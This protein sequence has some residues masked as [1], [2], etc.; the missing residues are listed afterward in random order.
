MEEFH[1]DGFRFDGVTSMLYHNHGHKA[2]G[3]YEDYFHDTNNDAILYLQLANHLI[4]KIKPNVLSICEDMSG[5]PGACRPVEEGGLGF[6]YRLAMGIPDYWLHLLETTKDEDWNLVDMYYRLNNRRYGE[7]NIAYAESHDQV[8]VGDKSIAFWLMDKE[9]YTSMSVFTDS[10]I[11]DR[12]IALHKMIRFITL[13]V[14]GEGY[15]NFMGNEFAHPEWVDFPREG[16]GWSYHYARRQWSLPD[17]DHLKYQYLEN[18]DQAMIHFAKDFGIV[19]E[20][21]SFKSYEHNEQKILIITKAGL[22]FVFNFSWNSYP[23]YQFYYEGIGNLKIIFNSDDSLYGGFRRV[24]NQINYP[25]IDNQVKVYLP[26][27]TLIVYQSN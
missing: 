20:E 4:H 16:N 11:V 8:L 2:F 27:R 21:F 19:S 15:M 18:F 1:F 5:I 6:D 7:K 13:L 3:S 25:I 10:L 22:V 9:M 17:T 14:G 23:D 12:G 26:S 24:D